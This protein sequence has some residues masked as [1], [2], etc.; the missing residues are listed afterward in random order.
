MNTILSD[1]GRLLC[2]KI[3]INSIAKVDV[4][5]VLLAPRV[6]PVLRVHGVFKA[7]KAIPVAPVLKVI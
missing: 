5:L 2:L 1:K 3:S 4:F 7:L 6:L